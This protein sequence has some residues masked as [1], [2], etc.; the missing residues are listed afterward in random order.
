MSLFEDIQRTR[1]EAGDAHYE[2]AKESLLKKI[3]KDPYL[4][5]HSLRCEVSAETKLDIIRRFKADGINAYPGVGNIEVDIN[6][7][8]NSPSKVSS[9]TS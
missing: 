8:P 9:M 3:R 6:Q 2:L 4:N 1:N 5:T 7:V